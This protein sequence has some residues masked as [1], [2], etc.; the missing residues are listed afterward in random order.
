MNFIYLCHTKN[1]TLTDTI[2]RIC[3]DH[4][5]DIH[6]TEENAPQFFTEILE[7][8]NESLNTL[9]LQYKKSEVSLFL[10]LL[11]DNHLHFSMFGTELTGIIVSEKNIEDVL[12]DM[13]TGEGHFVYDSHGD[14]RDNE[15]FYIFSPKTDT[16]VIGNECKTLGHLSLQERSELLADRLERSYVT[17]GI[18]M[19]IG[20]N[21]TT[22]KKEQWNPKMVG[23]TKANSKLLIEKATKM[24]NQGLQ[25]MSDSFTHLSRNAQNW[26]II[27]GIVLSFVLLYLIITSIVQS[28]YTLFVPQKY[29]DMLAEARVNLDDATRMVDQ[30]ENF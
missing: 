23:A 18:I 19:S 30:P 20:P 7:N 29:R 27:S 5:L 8:I 6:P 21:E 13:D 4:I 12:S 26:V 11:V 3:S 10:G 25:K 17:D 28:Q 16:H 14:I 1:S 15:T 22:S 24:S 9:Y 2:H